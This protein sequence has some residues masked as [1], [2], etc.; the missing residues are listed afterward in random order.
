MA[1]DGFDLDAYCLTG[2]EAAGTGL[3]Q[4][5]PRHRP[6]ERFLRGPVPWVWLT[7]AGSLP[8]R[9]LQVGVTLWQLA[10]VQG[11]RTV[12]F[13]LSRMRDMGVGEQA[14]RRA[15][16]ALE[17]A[18]LVSVSHKPGRGL[19]VTL[20]GAPGVSNRAPDPTRKKESQ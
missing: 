6:G 5:P 12:V 19:E 2:D 14:A 13:C 10:G 11:N 4:E 20:W 8:G 16:R 15:L 18:G 17:G 1:A 9:A 3:A 7:R